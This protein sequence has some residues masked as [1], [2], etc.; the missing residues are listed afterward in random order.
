[1]TDREKQFIKELRESHRKGTV[2]DARE[3]FNSCSDMV[4]SFS[5]PDPEVIEEIRNNK[6]MT[7]QMNKISWY[8]IRVAAANAS[9][10]FM[11]DERNEQAL[12][13]CFWLLMTPKGTEIVIRNTEDF[14]EDDLFGKISKYEYNPCDIGYLF[15]MMMSTE[16]RTIQQAFT[17]FVFTYLTKTNKEFHQMTKEA[18]KEELGYMQ[19]I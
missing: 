12:R 7:E 3:L 8:W 4:N 16:H 5:R 10:K 6:F 17:G 11:Y 15:A 1:M 14:K 2:T 9:K 18:G 13:T 19:M